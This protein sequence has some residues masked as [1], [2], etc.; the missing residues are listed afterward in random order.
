MGKI[1]A[2]KCSFSFQVPYGHLEDLKEPKGVFET[3][4]GV[5]CEIL[6]IRC[7]ARPCR[8]HGYVDES[9]NA[10][11]AANILLFIG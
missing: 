2:K 11:T 6:S 10:V 9:A 8:S 3:T 7:S 5:K 1:Q 4:P